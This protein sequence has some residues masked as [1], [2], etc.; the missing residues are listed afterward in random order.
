MIK[1]LGDAELEIMQIIWAYTEP[2]TSNEILSRLKRRQW[3][4]STLMTVLQRLVSKGFI[5]CD[6]SMRS[7]LYSAIITESKYNAS[8][9]KEFLGRL[10]GNSLRSFV[11]SFCGTNDVSKEELSELRSYLD[12][13]TENEIAE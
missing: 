11:A 13:F 12:G 4:L 10:Y 9:S 3:Q 8:E 2:M 6:R 5:L 7:N 1:R